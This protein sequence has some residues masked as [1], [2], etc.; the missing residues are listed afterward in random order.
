[1]AVGREHVYQLDFTTP[2]SRPSN[3]SR[4]K[5]MRHNPKRRM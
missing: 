2:G 4:R 1:M 5:Q 3:A